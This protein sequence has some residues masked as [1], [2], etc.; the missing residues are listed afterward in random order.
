MPTWETAGHCCAEM[1]QLLNW[2]RGLGCRDRGWGGGD[3]LWLLYCRLAVQ[4]LRFGMMDVGASLGIVDLKPVFWASGLGSLP[5]ELLT[6]WDR[7]FMVLVSGLSSEL[8]V[9]KQ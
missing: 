3:R 5:V 1:A 9:F 2:S 7:R 8:H 4:G 6:A